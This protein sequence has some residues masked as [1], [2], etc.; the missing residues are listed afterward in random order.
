LRVNRASST[1]PCHER[2]ERT[3]RCG[4]KSFANSVTFGAELEKSVPLVPSAH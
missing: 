4:W 2:F 1:L 3:V